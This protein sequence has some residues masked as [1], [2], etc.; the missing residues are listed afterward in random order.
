VDPDRQKTVEEIIFDFNV[1]Y[2]NLFC[3]GRRAFAKVS[4]RGIPIMKCPE[5]LFVIQE[6]VEETRPD[7]IVE[8]GVAYGGSALFFADLCALA[9]RGVII[10]CDRKISGINAKILEHPRIHLV[11]GD[12][13]SAHVFELISSYCTDKRVMVLLDSDHHEN[14]VSR[15]LSLYAPLVSKGCYLVVEDTNLNGHPSYSQ[16]GPG[17]FEAVQKFLR[18]NPQWKR[19]VHRERLLLTFNP[20]G[21]LLRN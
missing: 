17:P 15:E 4:W 14:H 20:S 6:I 10:A 8:I 19:D 18:E 11:E 1:L 9:D 12:S 2:Y 5:D 21:Y 3:S 16:F 13:T 7:V